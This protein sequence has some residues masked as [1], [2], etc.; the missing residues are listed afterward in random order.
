[1]ED[2]AAAIETALAEQGIARGWLLGE[3]FGSQVLWAL[4]A[5]SRL[6]LEGLILAGGFVR[7]PM[8]WG[9]HLA[10]RVCGGISLGLVT[11]ILFGYAKVARFRYRRSPEVQASLQEFIDRRTALDLQAAKHRLHL[12]AQND[13]RPVARQA[14]LPIYALT[15]LVDPVVPWCFVRPWLQKNCSS[16]REFKIIGCADHNVLG[17]AAQP[18][19]E[20]V[21][22]WMGET[23]RRA[24]LEKAGV[25]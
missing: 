6:Q 2:Y 8:R 17:T 22:R 13:L 25:A 3:S 18:A 5:R 7:H 1:M 10:E 23:A 4:A 20:Q 19:A 9:V 15:G 24:S 14:G 16:L 11:R 21:V 12:I